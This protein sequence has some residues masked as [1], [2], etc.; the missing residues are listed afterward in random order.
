[1]TSTPDTP[2][3]RRPRSRRTP[4][5]PALTSRPAK[6]RWRIKGTNT[7]GTLFQGQTLIRTCANCRPTP[8]HP[9]A[10]TRPG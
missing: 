4:Y 5:R 1:M 9:S 3:W 10:I 6:T 2:F 7:E 8:G